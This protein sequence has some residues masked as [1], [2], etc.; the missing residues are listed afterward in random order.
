MASLLIHSLHYSHSSTLKQHVLHFLRTVF[1]EE[2]KY[3]SANDLTSLI[4]PCFYR[5]VK[6]LSNVNCSDVLIAIN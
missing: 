5:N 4:I 2:L 3:K 6:V 1:G